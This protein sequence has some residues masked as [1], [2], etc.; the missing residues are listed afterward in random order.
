MALKY[1]MIETTN[2]KLKAGA[3]APGS[4]LFADEYFTASNGQ[5]IFSPIQVF[6]VASNIDVLLNGVEVREGAS[7]SYQRDTILN[8][9]VFSNGLLANA[10]VKIRI[11]I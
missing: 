4:A 3:S 7:F 1:A 5:T 11:W 2:G 8:R 9:I 6:G 10:E